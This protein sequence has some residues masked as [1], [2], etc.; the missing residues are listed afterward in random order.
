MLVVTAAHPKSEHPKDDKQGILP[1]FK[2][3]GAGE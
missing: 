2:N 3:W 1:V